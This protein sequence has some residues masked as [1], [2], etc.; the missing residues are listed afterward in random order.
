MN[1]LMDVFY[2]VALAIG[3]LAVAAVVVL[4]SWIQF[5]GG[6]LDRGRARIDEHLRQGTPHPHVGKLARVQEVIDPG[7]L[8]VELGGEVWPAK[9]PPFTPTPPNGETVR[10]IKVV[11]KVLIVRP[12]LPEA[13]AEPGASP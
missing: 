12:D 10:V 7:H 11:S 3:V 9:L 6:F 5:P 13:P 4:Y 8:W 2:Y 1:A